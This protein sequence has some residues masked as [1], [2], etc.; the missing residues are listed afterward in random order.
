MN[1]NGWNFQSPQPQPSV[2]LRSVQQVEGHLGIKTYPLRPGES[3][4]AIDTTANDIMWMKVCDAS[5]LPTIKRI[6]F[7]I[8]DDTSSDT[9]YVSRKDFDEL[10]KK[11]DKLLEGRN[12]K[13]ES[14]T[15]IVK[16]DQS[17]SNNSKSSNFNGRPKN[18]SS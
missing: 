18:A 16:S 4:I 13:S 11:L 10:S 3:V 5:G 15:A 1:F 6:R 2:P 8:E 12:D 14:T 7:K 9:D 17:N